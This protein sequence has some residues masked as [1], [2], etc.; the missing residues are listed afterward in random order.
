MDRKER[1]CA[2]TRSLPKLDDLPLFASDDA[3]SEVVMGKGKSAE[4]KQIAA[5]LERDGLPKINDL[6]GGRYVP[7]VKAFFDNDYGLI[8]APPQAPDGP[9]RLGS[10]K[11]RRKSKHL[12]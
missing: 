12:A 11:N 8:P 3:I 1:D 7:A 6:M 9:E 10:W 4:W 2:L 5:L